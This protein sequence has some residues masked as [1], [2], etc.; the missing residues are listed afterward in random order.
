[1]AID[2]SIILNLKQP[3]VPDI[4]GS[5]QKALTLRNLSIET[6]A[7]ERQLQE[8]QAM[9][10]AYRKNITMGPQGPTIN[11]QGVMADLVGV[12]PLRAIDEN[13]KL[14]QMD[15]DA[16]RRNAELGKE[17]AW[18]IRDPQTW[19]A[20]RQR[21]IELGLPN[22]ENLPEQYPGDAFVRSMQM[23]TLDYKEKLD[24][25]WKQKN[26]NL[27][28]EELGVSKQE[29]AR[30]AT[31]GEN[32]PIDA[33]KEVETLSTKNAG[34]VSIRNQINAVLS[35]WDKMSRDQQIAAGRQLIKTLNSTEGSDAV[36]V[37]E[38]NRL[39][40]K[41]EFAVGNLTN[42][43]PVQFG[44]DLEGFRTQAENVAAGIGRAVETNQER[45]DEL[46]GRRR[47]GRTPLTDYDAAA[48]KWAR[49]NPN[50]PRSRAILEA[51]GVTP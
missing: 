47:G 51:N 33:K 21:G 29:L 2:P 6:K 44:R 9:K 31:S 23:K 45:I 25:E 20:A 42:D 28:R 10:N 26:Y 27:Q 48:V 12:N 17:L 30:Q 11:R 46:M 22:A 38:A 35:G 14:Q 13:K 3:E 32:M 39:G 49:E 7:R 37:E 15:I 16:L 4:I 40:G 5:A 36:G 18:S 1:M 41:L 50:D 8:E 19:A 43:N 24:Q 34:K